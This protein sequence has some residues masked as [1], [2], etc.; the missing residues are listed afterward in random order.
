MRGMGAGSVADIHFDSEQ[1]II[2][3]KAIMVLSRQV[4]IETLTRG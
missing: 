2:I 1:V 3:N 4:F